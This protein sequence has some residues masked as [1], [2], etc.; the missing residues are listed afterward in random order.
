MLGSC[1]PGSTSNQLPCPERW[2]PPQ[3]FPAA[4]PHAH[5]P[6]PPVITSH[7]RTAPT[8]PPDTRPRRSVQ[9]SCNTAAPPPHTEPAQTILHRLLPIQPHRPPQLPATMIPVV[10]LNYDTHLQMAGAKA[11]L[12]VCLQMKSFS[13]TFSKEWGTIALPTASSAPLHS[14]PL[15]TRCSLTR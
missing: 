11:T 4:L 2:A 14:A 15:E 10:E 1:A 12:I 7:T 6:T 8:G 3:V 13:L 9:V 5:P